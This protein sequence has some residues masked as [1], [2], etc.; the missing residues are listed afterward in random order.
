MSDALCV[1][2]CE[3][4]QPM[5]CMYSSTVCQVVRLMYLQY[6]FLVSFL[7]VLFFVDV[8]IIMTETEDDFLRCTEQIRLSEYCSGGTLK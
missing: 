8:T 3:S 6:L 7:Y 5:R 1:K 2:Y 4:I